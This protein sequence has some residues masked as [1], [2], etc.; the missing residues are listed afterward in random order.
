ME[1]AGLDINPT[2]QIFWHLSVF[3][4]FKED[5]NFLIVFSGVGSKC[6]VILIGRENIEVNAIS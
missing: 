5:A 6:G 4:T 1:K 2:G 3:W